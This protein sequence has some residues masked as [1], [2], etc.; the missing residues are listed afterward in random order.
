MADD[1]QI[2][3]GVVGGQDILNVS[4]NIDSLSVNAKKLAL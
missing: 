3:V 4:K 1:V 2:K